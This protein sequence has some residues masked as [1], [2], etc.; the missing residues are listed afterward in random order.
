MK[1]MSSDEVVPAGKVSLQSIK[2]AEVGRARSNSTAPYERRSSLIEKSDV[3]PVKN[4]GH[5]RRSKL[6]EKAKQMKQRAQSVSFNDD[7]MREFREIL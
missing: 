6:A 3:R 4:F 7:N 2:Q 1:D 5:G